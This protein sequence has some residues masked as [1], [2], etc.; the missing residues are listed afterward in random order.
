MNR[1]KIFLYHR[2]TLYII[3]F[4]KGTLLSQSV[5][6]SGIVLD[7]S[8][9]TPLHGANIYIER[10]GLGTSSEVDGSFKVNKLPMGEISIKIS[11]MGYKEVTKLLV[12]EN[13]HMDL[14]RIFLSLDTLKIDGIV[15]EAHE[16]LKPESFI[17]NINIA[18]SKYHKNLKSTL[19]L[20]LQEQT[21][22]S[23]RSMGQA[24]AQPVLRGYKGHRFLLTDDGIATGDLSSTSIDHAVSTD[25]GSYSGIRIIRGPE[26]LLY[27][28]NT[29]GGVIDLS[30]NIDEKTR[31]HKLSLKTLFGTESSNN[32]RFGNIIAHL[33]FKSSH[34]MRLSFLSRKLGNQISP[35]GVLA[36][37]QSDNQEVHG[38]YSYF[39]DNFYSTFSLERFDLDYGIP[40]SPEGHIGGVD[41]AMFRNTQKLNF[42][43]DISIF[44]FQTLDIDQ[45]YIDY[46]HSESVK[47]A[48]YPSVILAQQIFSL[49]TKIKGEQKSIGSLLKIRNFQ[50]YEFYW[51]PD[52]QEIVISI[53]GL[54]E[55]NINSYTLQSS[56]R[57]ENNLIKP[58]TGIGFFGL[59]NLELDQIKDRNFLLFSAA[60]AIIGKWNKWD[61]SLGSMFT[62]R[63]PSI[64]DLY[65]DGPHLGVYNYEIGLPDLGAEHTFGFEGSLN[66]KNEKSQIKMTSFQNYSPNYHLSKQL[67]AGYEPGADW[68]EWGS[69]SAGWLYIYQMNGLET[70]IH[71]YELDGQYKLTELINFE[72]SFSA[73]RGKNLT[74]NTPLYYMPPDKILLSTEINLKPITLNMSFKKVFEQ[75]RTGYY[76]EGTAGYSIFNINGTFS[77]NQ[78]NFFHKFI[79]QVDNIFNQEYYNHLSRIKSIM[80]EKGRGVGIQYRLVF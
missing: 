12:L 48:T 65:S 68:I 47:G 20:T 21:G 69:G 26:T 55:K 80:P 52:A 54:N 74:E 41:I 70:Y 37:T 9:N 14:G 10:L 39:G 66:Y 76:E 78:T 3:I 4:I 24:T 59:S 43:K 17:S 2:L 61:F 18:G 44:G 53:Y 49:D 5:D 34:Q 8:K 72:G 79:L 75:S 67:G 50:A 45:R 73:T 30:R 46:E 11:M 62:S 38:S 23:I 60:T 15:V 19:A 36:N 22:L 63:A 58:N 6:I 40:G 31:F 51:T 13:T 27:G 25:M 56:F 7:N 16:E 57:L 29:I 35:V 42:H 71:G 28:S 77:I 32:G 33:P 1:M 64:E